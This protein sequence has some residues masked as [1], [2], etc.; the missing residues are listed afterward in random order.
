M[1]LNLSTS[2]NKEI[3]ENGDYINIVNNEKL[4]NLLL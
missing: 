3:L 2:P 4:S 1:V